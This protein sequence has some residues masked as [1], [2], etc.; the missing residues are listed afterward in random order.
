MVLAASLF[1]TLGFLSRTVVGLGMGA[2]DFVAWRAGLAMLVLIVLGLVLGP[3][4]AVGRLRQAS[5]RRQLALLVTGLLGALLNIAIFIAFQRTAIAL[6]LICLYTFPAMVTLAAVPLY[7]DRLERRRVIAL[8]VSSAGLV[9]VL[10]APAFDS[11]G[12]LLIDPLGVALA[13]FAAACQA[14]FVLITGRGFAPLNS[15]DVATFLLAAALV[16]S[17]IVLLA[18][19]QLDWVSAPL[20]EPRL[21][22]WLLAAGILGGTIPTVAWVAGIGIVGPAR[23]AILMTFEPVV[24]VT[25]AALLLGERPV[26]LQL[27]GGAAVLAAAV[28][29]QTTPSRGPVGPEA[30]IA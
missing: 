6:V 17:S 7:G 26:P 24:G 19:G 27:V 29:L 22:P 20:A 14:A 12:G 16:V 15:R 10:L 18:S 3:R 13:L 11:A 8:V 30:Q 1:G 2:V 23:A 5:R 4:G 21:W 9:L 25:L 28:L